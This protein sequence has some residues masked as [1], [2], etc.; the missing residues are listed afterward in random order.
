[1]S[2][3]DASRASP[4]GRCLRF[5]ALLVALL[6]GCRGPEAPARLPDADLHVSYVPG[7]ASLEF[8]PGAD[9][10]SP[11]HLEATS[12]TYDAQT[13]TVHARVSLRCFGSPGSPVRGEDGVEVFGVSPAGIGPA[14]AYA[15]PCYG[16]RCATWVFDHR[17]TF[18]NDGSLQLGEASE[19][20]EWIFDDPGNVGFSFRARYVSIPTPRQGEIAGVVFE[21]RDSNGVQDAG[22]PGLANVEI[23]LAGRDTLAARTDP[24]GRFV[25]AIHSPGRYALRREVLTRFCS[26]TPEPIEVS[27]EGRPDGSLTGFAAANF[28]CIAADLPELQLVD[29]RTRRAGFPPCASAEPCTIPALTPFKV[30]FTGVSHC[31][32]IRGL[33]WQ[34]VFP[35][36]R[37]ERF[38]PYGEESLFLDARRD[39]V[40]IGYTSGIPRD[41]L[42]TPIDPDTLWMLRQDTVTV[43]YQPPSERLPHSN[44]VGNFLFRARVT[45]DSGRRSS[46]EAGTHRIVLN[47]PPDTWIYRSTGCGQGSV[48]A[49]WITGNRQVDFPLDEWIPFCSGD[50]IPNESKVQVYAR[51]RDD[52]RDAPI[53]PRTGLQ[54]TGFAFRYAWSR[55]GEYDANIPYSTTYAPQTLPL[56]G[57]GTWRGAS[58]GWRV[59]PLDYVLY[60]G[61]IDEHDMLDGTPDSLVFHVGRA[62]VID[63]VLVPKVVIFVPQCFSGVPFCDSVPA[64]GRDTLAVLGHWIP[65]RDGSTPL[66][67]GFNEFDFPL[68]AW[69]H[70]H[71]RDGG[72]VLAW[73][74]SFDCVTPGCDDL[75]LPGEG[76]WSNDIERESDPPGEQVFD[77]DWRL[78]MPLDTLCTTTPCSLPAVRVKL[79]F[80]SSGE[81]L[82]T[83]QGRDTD[84]LSQFCTAPWDLNPNYSDRRISISEL[85]LTTQVVSR[86]VI[87]RQLADVRP[88][89]QVT[90]PVWSRRAA[91]LLR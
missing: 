10:A 5:V 15:I 59:C 8:R 40:A 6:S 80:R 26:T 65:D 4:R 32:G 79:G 90:T 70:D 60:A 9:W 45:D 20:V 24:S 41:S 19:P 76:G 35:D 57:G 87:W 89:Q 13:Q 50:T 1:M 85:G 37:S 18:G 21:D 28:G 16:A 7:P 38:Q 47:Y 86:H 48:P 78:M 44:G 66:R 54:E 30:R 49:G 36:G 62:P 69:G 29:V 88:P 14:N 39:T 11:L 17:D 23:M 71:P 56:P 58:I 74:C 52:P 3:G 73:K 72:W 42:W 63:S 91:P 22:E 67:L 33:Q 82:F 61:A 64:F 81:Y 31:R 27:I 25:F 34:A 84:A 83:I 2:A 51:G 46:L 43:F 77:P 12:V 68:R 53:D 75:V 55:A